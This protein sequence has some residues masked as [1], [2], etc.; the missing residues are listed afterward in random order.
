MLEARHAARRTAALTATESGPVRLL[1]AASR[2]SLRLPER[3]LAGLGPV[4]GLALDGPINCFTG[5]P[6]ARCALRLGPDEWLVLGP[7]ADTDALCAELAE[8]LAGRF[9]ALTDVS[10][11]NVALGA[12][13]PDAEAILNA[14]CPLDLHPKTFP[15]GAGTRTLLGKAEIVL[16]RTGETTFHVE[17]WR[18]FAPY[19]QGFL[20]EAARSV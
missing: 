2:L 8:G 14:G 1:P 3:A 12:E 19:V 11:R 18:S 4:A 20:I 16:L 6:D 5:A 17:C 7:E 15:V 13:S 10:H 9:H